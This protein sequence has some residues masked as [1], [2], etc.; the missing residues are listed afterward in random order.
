MAKFKYNAPNS[1]TGSLTIA[2]LVLLFVGI[3][4]LII[5]FNTQIGSW[6][7]TFGTAFIVCAVPLA[8]FVI[9]TIINKKIKEM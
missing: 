4:L 1:K 3:I 5:G 6:L 9:Y 8:I 2:T 7:K